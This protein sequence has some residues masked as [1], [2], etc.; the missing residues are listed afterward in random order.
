MDPLIV[1]QKWED[2]AEYLYCA[3]SQIP[4]SERYTMGSGMRASLF[5]CG[6][7][8]IKANKIRDKKLRRTEI[9]NADNELANIKIMLRLAYRMKFIDNKKY[10]ISSEKLT[11]LGKILG[12]WLKSTTT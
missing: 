4:K 9:E 3:F 2:A 11:E 8:I 12:G 10:Q 5:Q 6:A 1:Y 7:S